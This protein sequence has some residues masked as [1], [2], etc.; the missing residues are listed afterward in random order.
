MAIAINIKN[1]ILNY[2]DNGISISTLALE[3]S[4]AKSSIYRWLEDRKQ[5]R[6]PK[7]RKVPKSFKKNY[8]LNNSEKKLIVNLKKENKDISYKEILSKLDHKVSFRAIFR[9]LKKAGLTRRR[10]FKYPTLKNL[11]KYQQ[12]DLEFLRKE[13]QKFAKDKNHPKYYEIIYSF[14]LIFSNRGLFKEVELV[15]RKILKNKKKFIENLEKK[16]PSIAGM[17]YYSLGDSNN[18]FAMVEKA[19]KDYSKAYELFEETSKGEITLEFVKGL[20][21]SLY[22]DQYK[23]KITLESL[24]SILQETKNSDIKAYIYSALGVYAFEKNDYQTAN[25]N[26]RESLK[27][28]EKKDDEYG[29]IYLNLAN[30]N[31]NMNKNKEALNF[32]DLAEEYTRFDSFQKAKIQLL[33][34]LI[35]VKEKKSWQEIEK[36]YLK[37]ILIFKKVKNDL[38]YLFC[39]CH[40]ALLYYKNH[41]ITKLNKIKPFIEKYLDIP[42]LAYFARRYLAMVE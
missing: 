17:I 15:C 8:K 22:T 23:T 20:A 19:G 27:F 24:N 10:N 33:R 37:S 4:I 29:K 39:L 13:Y 21:R 9:Y 7:K 5:K 3:Y 12:E 6:K 31:N 42:E 32:L 34:G 25:K 41:K 14:L 2:F 1:E 16:D 28:K 30:C 35:A 40:L 11:E 38:H 26:L 36:L 18:S